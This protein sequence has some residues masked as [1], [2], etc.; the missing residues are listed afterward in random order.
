MTGVTSLEVSMMGT[1][2]TIVGTDIG[3]GELEVKMKRGNFSGNDT[4]LRPVFRFP[5]AAK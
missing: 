1:V 5:A 3:R 2:I 4:N